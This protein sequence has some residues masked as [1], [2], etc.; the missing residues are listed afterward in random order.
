MPVRSHQFL[1]I[2]SILW[3][4]W[5]TMMLVH[6]GGHVLGALATGGKVRLVVWH[7]AVMSRTDVSPNPHPLVE[8]W[9]GPIVGSLFPAVLAVS[10]MRLRVAYLV[11]TVAGF[12]LIANGAYIGSGAI[13][14]VGDAAELVAH[15][16]SR[17]ILAMFGLVTV[18]S[19]LWIW[20][21]AS[22]R[23]GFGAASE[24][25]QADHAYGTF[26]LAV[27]MTVVGIAGGSRSG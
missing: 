6:E 16:M 12:C 20:H 25:I 19:G 17:W 15:G 14:P 21:R 8:V 3:V 27:L 5:L 9:A 1:L 22:S 2:A 7:P 4:S 26:V 13:Q 23:L 11:R 24:A 10:C 18:T